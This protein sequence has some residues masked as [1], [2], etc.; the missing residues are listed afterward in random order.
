MI[1]KRILTF[2]L[3]VLFS[4]QG[5]TGWAE[6]PRQNRDR[7]QLGVTGSISSETTWTHIK[8]LRYEQVQNL[9]L[10]IG[11]NPRDFDFVSASLD[12]LP[13]G[14]DEIMDL[15][16]LRRD[17]DLFY[18]NFNFFT[19]EDLR[20]MFEVGVKY[21]RS[22]TAAYTSK[23]PEFWTYL[24]AKSQPHI[25]HEML[26]Y[27]LI[28]CFSLDWDGLYITEQ[29][30]LRAGATHTEG[31]NSYIPWA[32]EAG[33]VFSLKHL[34]WGSHN[35][36]AQNQDYAFSSFGDH[37]S[38]R[39]MLP[40][41]FWYAMFS[42]GNGRLPDDLETKTQRATRPFMKTMLV[43]I[44]QL[45]RD[46][47]A[48]PLSLAEIQEAHA[49]T[50]NDTRALLE[51]L[52]DIQMVTE[53]EDG[54]LAAIPVLETTDQAMID[55]VLN[56]SQTIMKD[57]LEENYENLN[58][59]LEG[60]TA[61]RQGVDLKIVFTQVWHFIFGLTNRDLAGAGMFVDPYGEER[62]YPGAIP[63][64]WDRHIYEGYDPL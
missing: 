41:L 62:T 16:L 10:A 53:T 4:I 57:W 54:Y 25:S 64:L 61:L 21:A 11:E 40:D 5:S 49:F 55:Q 1:F 44:G 19:Q 32:K 8:M 23:K 17:G 52:V 56:L 51:F 9:F 14:L 63:F 31:S 33:E 60:V 28:G 18:I 42:V 45:L 26:A 59:D 20:L 58:K 27:I 30:G 34:Y 7:F 39:N 37:Y 46:I 12:G 29:M 13:F 50:E 35:Q 3:L 36:L 24:N 48:S 2:T 38:A 43:Q 22:L 47:K 15:R 6:E